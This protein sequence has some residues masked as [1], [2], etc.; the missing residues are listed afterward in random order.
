MIIMAAVFALPAMAQWS[1]TATPFAPVKAP[2]AAFCSTSCMTPSGSPHS[3]NPS[4]N[5]DGKAIYGGG[6]GSSTSTDVPRNPRRI[7]PP[8]P[9]TDPMP[10]GDAVLPL[11]LM[12]LGY[13]LVL[14]TKP[15]TR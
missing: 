6:S 5:A 13:I 9:G 10:L 2:V 15:L 4:L 11:L 1:T 12:A 7:I 8:N 3:F 14:R